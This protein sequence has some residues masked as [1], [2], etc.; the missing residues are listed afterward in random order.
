MVKS[1]CPEKKQEFF[2]V[3]LAQWSGE[4]KTFHGILRDSRRQKGRSLSIFH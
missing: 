1:I 2:N 3:C 4:L